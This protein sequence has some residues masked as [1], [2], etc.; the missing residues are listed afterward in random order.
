MGRSQLRG[1]IVR[2]SGL[3]V[4]SYYGTGNAKK[5]FEPKNRE[6][7]PGIV[8]SEFADAFW[9]GQSDGKENAQQHAR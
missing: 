8:Q 9:K 7:G 5:G 4:K 6:F 3:G 2:D 1:R